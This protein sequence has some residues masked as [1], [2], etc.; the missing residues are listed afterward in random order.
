MVEEFQMIQTFNKTKQIHP[1]KFLT[2]PNSTHVPVRTRSLAERKNRLHLKLLWIF[3]MLPLLFSQSLDQ[4][5]PLWI[6]IP[7]QKSNYFKLL[8]FYSLSHSVLQKIEQQKIILQI[9]K[10]HIKFV[11]YGQHSEYK[12]FRII[13]E[14]T[15]ILALKFSSQGPSA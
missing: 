15:K 11:L 3:E 4:K 8:K 14:H 2:R 1:K 7:D 13:S 9:R 12:L 5:Q 6:Q 10:I